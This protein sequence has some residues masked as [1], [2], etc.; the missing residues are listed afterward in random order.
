MWN[1]RASA[2]P[3]FR[4]SGATIFSSTAFSTVLTGTPA[5]PATSLTDSSAGIICPFQGT[6]LMDV[7]ADRKATPPVRGISR[8]RRG[9]DAR[10][11]TSWEQSMAILVEC[12]GAGPSRSRTLRAMFEDRRHV[13]VDLLKWDLPVL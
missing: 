4:L 9:S 2:F 12:G 11:R 1:G 13:F 5:R 6:N 8:R 3:R 10:S 7:V